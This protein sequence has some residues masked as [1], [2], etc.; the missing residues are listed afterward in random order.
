M[1]CHGFPI[2]C[3]SVIIGSNYVE[4]AILKIMLSD[5][6]DLPCFF[7]EQISRIAEC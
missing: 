3:L 6:S 5:V 1:K 2:S 7:P 4:L